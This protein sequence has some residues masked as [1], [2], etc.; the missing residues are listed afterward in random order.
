M[1]HGSWLRWSWRLDT[2]M[3]QIWSHIPIC[4][5]E[6]K[7]SDNTVYYLYIQVK[8]ISAME[9]ELQVGMIELINNSRK[10]L[11]L[12]TLAWLRRL[13]KSS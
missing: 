9:R 4:T 2:H 3:T 10:P 1:Y 5:G 7:E 11:K 13:N 8:Q 6:K 12:G